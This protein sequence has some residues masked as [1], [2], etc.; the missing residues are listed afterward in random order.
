MAANQDDHPP[1]APPVSQPQPHEQFDQ[2]YEEKLKAAKIH[3]DLR[4]ADSSTDSEGDDNER[5]TWH[6]SPLHVKRIK[7]KERSL[8]GEIHYLPSHS[9]NESGSDSGKPSSPR[10]GVPKMGSPSLYRRDK[11]K[12]LRSPRRLSAPSMGSRSPR[13]YGSRSLGESSELIQV[14]DE[15]FIR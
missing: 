7:R 4:H 2:S 8:S 3:L 12:Q 9:T 10:R 14:G 5:A 13:K 6:K 15:C 1:G 11:P